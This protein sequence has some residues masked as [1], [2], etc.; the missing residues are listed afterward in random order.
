MKKLS[1]KKNRAVFLDRDGVINKKPAE[2]DYVKSWGEFEFLPG[3]AEF[4]REIRK[5][6]L[7]IVI[8]NQR[9]VSKGLMT[10]GDLVNV[11]K[12]MEEELGKKKAK[13]DG[14]Y[15]CPHGAED[16]CSC[17]KPKPGMIFS[18]A[19]DFDIDLSQSFLI[20][21]AKSDIKVG[22][23][24]GCK[25]ILVDN[26]ISIKEQAIKPDF[27]VKNIFEIIKILE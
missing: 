15:F 19:K 21:D 17:R 7:V 11:H 6:F 10:L 5:K 22:K 26:D 3:V 18:A 12:K 24:A 9:G 23:R 20:G 4:I 27:L 14:I 13:I 25:T 8:T 2:H 16:S 1:N